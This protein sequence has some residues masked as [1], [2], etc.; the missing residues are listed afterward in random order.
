VLSLVVRQTTVLP[1]LETPRLETEPRTWLAAR[2][3]ARPTVLG[4]GLGL[5]LGLVSKIQ[6]LSTKF[7]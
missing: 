1:Q 2:P 7:D 4:L 3:T 6:I 5:G